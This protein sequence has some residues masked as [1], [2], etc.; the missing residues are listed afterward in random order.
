MVYQRAPAQPGAS[1]NDTLMVGPTLYPQLTDILIRFRA[2]PVAISGDVAKMYRAVE[3]APEDRDLHRFIWRPDQSSE[4][5]DYRMKRVTFGIAASPFLAV[6]ALQQTAHKFGS[7][8][9][10]AYSHVFDSFYV[11]DCLAGADT[12]EQALELHK[13]L[14]ELLNKGGFD[15]RKWRSSS[16]TVV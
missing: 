12:P 7:E 3:L 14:R 1:L 8:F 11:D 4:P 5:R 10:L 6:Q 13:Q 16:S 15:L 2:F 9:P